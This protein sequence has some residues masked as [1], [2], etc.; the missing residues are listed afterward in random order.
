MEKFSLRFTIPFNFAA[1]NRW[2]N[3]TDCT[4]FKYTDAQIGIGVA[5]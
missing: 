5:F 1:L 4:A 2:A 3:V